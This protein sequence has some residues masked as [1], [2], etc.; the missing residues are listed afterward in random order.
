MEDEETD[1]KAAQELNRYRITLDRDPRS[2]SE[3]RLITGPEPNR[4]VI[5]V[6]QVRQGNR[7]KQTY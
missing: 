1:Y 2:E 7:F 6:N 4:V 3:V 5:P